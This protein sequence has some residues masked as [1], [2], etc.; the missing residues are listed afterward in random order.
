V[1]ETLSGIL[2]SQDLPKLPHRIVLIM[3]GDVAAKLDKGQIWKKLTA[4][5]VFIAVLA[6]SVDC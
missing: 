5:Q 2:L 6:Q 1:I 3:V 4:S